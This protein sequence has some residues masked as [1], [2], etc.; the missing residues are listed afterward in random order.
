MFEEIHHVAV[1]ESLRVLMNDKMG[2]RLYITTTKQ[3]SRLGHHELLS[4]PSYHSLFL[5]D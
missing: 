4:F 1:R 3:V 5:K 2:R